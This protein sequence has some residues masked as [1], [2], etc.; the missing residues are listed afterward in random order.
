MGRNKET[1]PYVDPIIATWDLFE[2]SGSI[3]YYLLYKN[4]LK[5]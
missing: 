2:K 1:K 5:K 3:S 4:L